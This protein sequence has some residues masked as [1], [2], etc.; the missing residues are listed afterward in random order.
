VAGGPPGSPPPLVPTPILLR[1][2]LEWD[3]A[4]PYAKYV[5]R[6][7]REGK[8]LAAA[9]EARNLREARRKRRPRSR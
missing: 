9:S 8:E 5:G 1:V 3:A 4:L 7:T 6:L 2:A